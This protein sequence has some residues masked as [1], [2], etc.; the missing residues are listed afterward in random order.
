MNKQP[1]PR[2][3]PGIALKYGVCRATIYNEIN[4]GKLRLTKIGARTIITEH[5]EKDWVELGQQTAAE[6]DCGKKKSA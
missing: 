4:R 2:S 5:D 1:H 6:Q 3:I